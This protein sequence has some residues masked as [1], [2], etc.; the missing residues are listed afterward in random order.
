MSRMTHH[1][2]P[3]RILRYCG[4]KENRDRQA[5][6]DGIARAWLRTS[7]KVMATARRRGITAFRALLEQNDE[8]VVQGAARLCWKAFASRAVIPF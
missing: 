8:R 3:V 6:R 4:S 5:A 2:F 1:E 7:V